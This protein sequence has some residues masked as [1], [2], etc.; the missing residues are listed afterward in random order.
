MEYWEAAPAAPCK[1]SMQSG[2]M[3]WHDIDFAMMDVKSRVLE[4]KEVAG[5]DANSVIGE[6]NERGAVV[7]AG[8]RPWKRAGPHVY[9]HAHGRKLDELRAD[10]QGKLDLLSAENKELRADL[11]GKL[12]LLSAVNNG[13]KERIR[14]LEGHELRKEVAEG[15]ELQKEVA[16]FDVELQVGDET[17]ASNRRP[18]M[19]ASYLMALEDTEDTEETEQHELGD[20]MWDA[21]LFLGCKDELNLKGASM[22]VGILVT[23]FGALALVINALIQTAIVYVVVYKMADNADIKEG[24]VADMRRVAHAAEAL[25]DPRQ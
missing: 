19:I 4:G 21:C 9:T 17:K 25:T 8:A 10:L 14:A 12:D 22:N 2:S 5:S 18:S 24:T 20:S 16:V 7:G 13:L 1:G 23:I 15:Q 6:E 3:I 11:Q